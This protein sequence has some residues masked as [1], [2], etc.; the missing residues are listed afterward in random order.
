MSVS[1][2]SPCQFHDVLPMLLGSPRLRAPLLPVAVPRPIAFSSGTR[3]PPY[4]SSVP[5]RTSPRPAS[6]SQQ[7]RMVNSL[8]FEV[9]RSMRI[10]NPVVSK[11]A[12]M[13]LGDSS[14][15]RVGVLKVLQVKPI[16]PDA[17]ILRKSFYV[18]KADGVRRNPQPRDHLQQANPLKN[19]FPVGS[20]RLVQRIA[21]G[22]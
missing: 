2:I 9:S 21:K 19:D 15:S 8:I 6:A 12:Q 20:S 3:N 5:L 16:V 7:S 18:D 22:S 10:E 1:L 17:G 11:D 13:R 4:R 14:R